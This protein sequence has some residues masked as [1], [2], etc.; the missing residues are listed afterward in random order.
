MFSPTEVCNAKR[1][2]LTHFQVFHSV[3]HPTWRFALIE[4][5]RWGF[6]LG[7]WRVRPI[8][9]C[10]KPT[11]W[12]LSM[13]SRSR[14]VGAKHVL[15][16]LGS[17]HSSQTLFDDVSIFIVWAIGAFWS[18]TRKL[19]KQIEVFVCILQPSPT[20]PDVGCCQGFQTCCRFG[21]LGFDFRV[22]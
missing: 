21:G 9:F 3:Q 5:F 18:F 2:C 22:S 16:F 1:I 15:R 17:I 20:P 8:Q 10:C 11:I 12:A 14:N 7:E 6:G 4:V 13:E 19:G